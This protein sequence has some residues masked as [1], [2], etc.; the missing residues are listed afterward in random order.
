MLAR[1]GIHEQHNF[2]ASEAEPQTDKRVQA[3]GFGEF[4]GWP[5]P[6][7]GSPVRTITQQNSIRFSYVK[8]YVHYARG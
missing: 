2:S 4:R 1:I 5:A 7:M 3:V 6:W 8:R